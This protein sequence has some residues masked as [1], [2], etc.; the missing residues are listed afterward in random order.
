M[1]VGSPYSRLVCW[2]ACIRFVGLM[3]DPSMGRCI[4][5]SA[6]KKQPCWANLPLT[7]CST[8]CSLL[9][10]KHQKKNVPTVKRYSK[11]LSTERIPLTRCFKP[12]QR[13]AT[14]FCNTCDQPLCTECKAS[15][16]AAKMFAKH[17]TLLWCRGVAA[18]GLTPPS[19][20]LLWVAQWS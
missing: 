1:H 16:H 5:L 14:L 7:S 2:L 8:S 10:R 20:A 11:L 18:R 15:T 17:G 6:S 4:A 12:I 9:P 13:V 3:L 19:V